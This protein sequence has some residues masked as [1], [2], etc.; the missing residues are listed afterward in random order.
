MSN[1]EPQG[2]RRFRT[3]DQL[4]AGF[5]QLPPEEQKRLRE[6]YIVDQLEARNI[7]Q[8]GAA[9]SAIGENDLTVGL[10]TIQN[11][12]TERKIYSYEQNAQMGSGQARLRVKGGDTQFIV[13]ILVT[14]GVIVVVLVVLFM[15]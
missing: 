13:P 15:R 9:Q 11:L 5:E 2:L 3:S 1:E 4:P 10:Q 12:N 7:A 8:R 14:I 6:K